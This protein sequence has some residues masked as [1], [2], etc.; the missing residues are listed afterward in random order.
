LLTSEFRSMYEAQVL[1]GARIL[2]KEL[3]LPWNWLDFVQCL[4]VPVIVRTLAVSREIAMAAQIRNFGADT[5][6]TCW[7][8]E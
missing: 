7:P 5:T 1:R 4:L 2:P 3:M 8:Y 6:R